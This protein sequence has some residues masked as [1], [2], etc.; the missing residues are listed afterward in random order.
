[1]SRDFGIIPTLGSRDVTANLL[2]H[3]REEI[4]NQSADQ[5]IFFIMRA[6]VETVNSFEFVL[7]SVKRSI[8]LTALTLLRPSELGERAN[9]I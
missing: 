6:L 8:R 1:M 4:G 3:R 5:R 7:D 2:M 9:V